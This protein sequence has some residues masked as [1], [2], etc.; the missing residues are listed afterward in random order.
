[1]AC[2]PAGEEFVYNELDD[3]LCL[4]DDECW[5]AVD[6][7]KSISHQSAIN[8]K[9][10]SGNEKSN[11]KMKRDSHHNDIEDF[12]IAVIQ[13]NVETVQQFL[14]SG[15]DLDTCLKG[16]WTA[17]MYAC[18]HG[19]ADIVELLLNCGANPNAHKDMFSALMCLCACKKF[20]EDDLIKATKLLVNKGARV[21]AHD[22]H[23]MTPLLY[24]SQMSH[25]GIAEVLLSANTE[26]NCQDSQGWTPLCYAA[27][28]DNLPLV[29]L[30]LR[31]G[32]S[33]QICTQLGDTPSSLALSCGYMKIVNVL[34]NGERD[35]KQREI[36][37]LS[38]PENVDRE[39]TTSE[40]ILG[41]PSSVNSGSMQYGDLELF[42]T[43]L[44]LGHLV[45]L[46]QS[47]RVK[48]SSVLSM[49][50]K[51]FED[52][53]ISQVGVRKI[54]IS[55]ITDLHKT[56]WT[57]PN[58]PFTTTR[59][60][61]LEEYSIVLSQLS[62]HIS[63]IGGSTSFI[64]NHTST[65]AP[66]PV[67]MAT[68]YREQ[69]ELIN[70]VKSVVDASGSLHQK[71]LQLE[72]D[73]NECLGKKPH[74]QVSSS[75]IHKTRIFKIISFSVIG[76]ASFSYLVYFCYGNKSVLFDVFHKL[77]SHFSRK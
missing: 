11:G 61:S 37:S 59:G 68:D 12:R 73:I 56:N 60:L 36:P 17:L 3:E 1:M 51:D 44:Q 29:N 71:V 62:R 49:N 18:D 30:L 74:S 33:P 40:C 4:G 69:Q 54:L 52:M 58:K 47:H 35:L 39:L 34:D 38:G 41:F 7:V 43:G 14:N 75:R 27:R 53:G 64:I 20:H 8:T 13:G 5:E 9:D 16:G 65:N 24:A 70:Q 48:F 2:V 6:Y 22:R 63:Y 55:A 42:L 45:P 10:Q 31:G 77:C 76:I 46:F 28:N 32:A 72:N 19:N 50:D 15:F 67:T 21:N 25:L 57:M 26:I 23:L 66:S